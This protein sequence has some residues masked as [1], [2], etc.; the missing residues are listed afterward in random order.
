MRVVP[1]AQYV[2]VS[3]ITGSI[4]DVARTGGP[5]AQA[6]SIDGEANWTY[7]ELVNRSEELARGL[8]GIGVEPGDRVGILLLNSL[9]YFALYFAIARLGG[10]SVRLNWRLAP[11]ELEYIVNDSACAV[12]CFHSSLADRL[13]LV[14]GRGRV[15]HLLALEEPGTG[16][17]IPQWALPL[18]ESA[19][20]QTPLPTVRIEQDD[21]VML[22]YTSGTTGRPKGVKWTHA[23]TLWHASLQAMKF[24]F[25]ED[26]VALTTG[27]FYHAGAFEVFLLPALLS[28]GRAVG[29]SSGGFSIDRL[30]S[31]IEQT[32]VT[33]VLLYPFMLYDLLRH[34]RCDREAL[35][36][37]RRIKCGGDTIMPWAADALRQSL[38]GVELVVTYGLTEGGANSTYLDFTDVASHGNTVGRPLPLTRVQVIRPDWTQAEPGEVG[39]IA[40]SGPAV[41]PGYWNAPE[42]TAET[43]VDGWCRTGDL[44][45]LDADGYLM[46]TGR[47][48]DMIRSGGEN[49][50]PA[51]VEAVLTSHPAVRDAA[52]IGV[53]D[54]KY[55]EVGCAVVVIDPR[56][57]ISDE[58]LREHCRAHLAAYKCP[59]HWVRVEELPRNPAGK[60]LK[61]QLRDTYAGIGASIPAASE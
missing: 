42:A 30:V 6:I 34:P 23:N 45:T 5:Q 8:A 17:P 2:D 9:D 4:R 15:E 53:P 39:E 14:R 10:I 16:A 40:V 60:V 26:T 21:V 57:P 22:M 54:A 19:R 36:S 46:V 29:L 43:F 32:G 1:G 35:T 7:D 52:L 48:K 50:Y 37:L 27:P 3:W 18:D 24:G 49:I 61:Y 55:V 51:E 28:R 12:L 38:P 41:S 56:T 13:D 31:V 44:G 33:D 11:S 58:E 47:L 59:K 25:G 20:A